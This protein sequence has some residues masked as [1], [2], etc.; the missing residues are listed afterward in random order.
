MFYFSFFFLQSRYVLQFFFQYFEAADH[1]DM[2]KMISCFNILWCHAT[3]ASLTHIDFVNTPPTH[4]LDSLHKLV[5][6]NGGTFSMNLN[7]SVTHCVAAQ[8]KGLFLSLSLSYLYIHTDTY[9]HL[10]A[11]MHA[12]WYIKNILQW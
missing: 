11:Y 12:W 1:L 10:H 2:S 3:K 7:N 4:S 8:S 6:E 5:V 9:R